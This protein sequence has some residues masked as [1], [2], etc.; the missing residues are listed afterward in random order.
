MSER[1]TEQ[2]ETDTAE[3][4]ISFRGF[5]GRSTLEN[6]GER[7]SVI[8]DPETRTASVYK[9]IG[10]G[11]PERVWH[12]RARMFGIDEALSLEDVE[13]VLDSN[14]DLIRELFDL[15]EGKEWNGQN[16]VGSWSNSERVEEID[17]LLSDACRDERVRR[18][19]SAGDWFSPAKGEMMDR[20]LAKLAARSDRDLAMAISDVLDEEELG[21]EGAIVD[22]DEAADQLMEWAREDERVLE[23]L[24]GRLVDQ[25]DLTWHTSPE[26]AGTMLLVEYACDEGETYRRVTDL[27]SKPTLPGYRTYEK[28]AYTIEA[29]EPWNGIV[30]ESEN[31]EPTW[32]TLQ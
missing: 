8:L 15:Y 2:T 21:V 11:C 22:E 6:R 16:H 1:A 3:T 18:Y 32:E 28:S 20:V 12:H 14:A 31:D 23:L 7:A 4:A 5:E 29:F 26:S 10:S 25:R 30:L 24:A 19:W 13:N 9:S 27:S 17:G